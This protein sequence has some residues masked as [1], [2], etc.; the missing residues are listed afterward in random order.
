MLCSPTR[1]SGPVSRKTSS[2]VM[3][4]SETSSSSTCGAMESSTSSRTG[5]PKRRRSSSFSSALRRFSASSSSTSRSSLR[6]TR[7]LCDLEHLHAGEELLEVLG[8]DVLERDE[9]LVAQRHE[10]G[11]D[12]RHLD[13]GEVLLVGLGVAHQH[14]EVERQPGDVGERVRRVDGERRQHREDPLLEQPLAELLL[15]AV[16]LVPADQVDALLGELGHELLAE[17]AGVPLHQ[18]AG[19]G[20]D[21]LEHL[22][23]HQAG[24]G[25]DRDVGRDPALEAGHPDHEELVEVVGEDR[26]EAHPLQQRQRGVLGQ[27][28]DPL[29]EAQP[30]QLAVEEA[31]VVRRDRRD[32]RLVGLVGGL[33]VERLVGRDV[34]L[35]RGVEGSQLDHGIQCGTDRCAP[36][37]WSPHGP[38]PGS[39]P[40][41]LGCRT[42]LLDR[43]SSQPP[44]CGPRR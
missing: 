7:K 39:R 16:Q 15:L 1:S 10:A 35:A 23:R 9:A 5:G 43:R 25:A 31:V 22:A 8:D 29:V 40:Q 36:G 37:T 17:E 33:Y 32:R 12:R 21:L 18:V 44:T 14:G 13:P 4:S 28:E 20:P 42:C 19:A 11:E 26:R 38:G 27:L 30:G 2:S 3:P 34:A 6:V 24:G 41:W